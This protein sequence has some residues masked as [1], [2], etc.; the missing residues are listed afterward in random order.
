[1]ES[2]LDDI[3]AMIGELDD[4]NFNPNKNIVSNLINL[5]GYSF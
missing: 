5:K 2:I 3:D 4:L 1:M